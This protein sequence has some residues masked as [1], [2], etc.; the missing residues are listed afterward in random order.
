M[1]TYK[2][3]AGELAALGRDR[4]R[5]QNLE[6]ME[7]LWKLELHNLY[8]FSQG[9]F[10]VLHF[11]YSEVQQFPGC[12]LLCSIVLLGIWYGLL[13]KK[14]YGLETVVGYWL[15]P[16]H[17]LLIHEGEH[18]DVLVPDHGGGPLVLQCG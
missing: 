12:V 15:Q 7:K 17:P 11:F 2:V 13:C 3:Q 5:A 4:A 9:Q 10:Y 6:M 1:K 8:S 18:V 14:S 16:A